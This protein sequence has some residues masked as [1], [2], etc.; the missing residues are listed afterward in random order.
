MPERRGRPVKS[1][2]GEAA[3]RHVLVRLIPST[4]DKLKAKASRSG[5]PVA[6]YVRSLIS[7]DL[8]F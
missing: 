2:S 4:H 8:R 6:E 3:T 1:L 5:Q 7:R